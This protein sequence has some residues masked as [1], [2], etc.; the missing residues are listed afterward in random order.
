MARTKR[1]TR[2]TR[3]SRKGPNAT[4][5]LD[6]LKASAVATVSTLLEQGVELHQKGR[7][8]AIDSAKDARKVVAERAGEARSRTMKAVSQLERAFEERVS[9]AIASL[10]VPSSRDVR[11]LSQQLAQ[12]QQSVDQ[13]RRARARA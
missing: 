10:G 6:R 11:A 7:K 8:L 12:L 3:T 2:I 1:T 4:A 5:R 9:K 13:L